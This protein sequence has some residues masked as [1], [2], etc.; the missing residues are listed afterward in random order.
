MEVD[1]AETPIIDEIEI[2]GC[3]HFKNSGVEGE[4]IGLNAKKILIRGGEFYIG[5]KD[6]RF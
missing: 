5:T 1:V 3:L 6:N 2:N 4:N